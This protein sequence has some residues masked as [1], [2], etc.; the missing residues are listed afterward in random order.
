MATIPI[1]TTI[2]MGI[3]GSGTIT[4][5]IIGTSIIMATAGV[6]KWYMPKD[7]A[8]F[9]GQRILSPN[10]AERGMSSIPEH[11]RTNPGAPTLEAR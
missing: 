3:T 6:Q 5:T 10:R 4:A 8:V 1:T 7:K 2:I 11:I 9:T